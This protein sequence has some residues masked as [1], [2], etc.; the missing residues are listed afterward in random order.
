M[1]GLAASLLVTALLAARLQAQ[2]STLQ[3]SGPF[4]TS[5][6]GLPLSSDNESLTIGPGELG[7]VCR[8]A[9]HVH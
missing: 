1:K 9:R 8:T 5:N 6:F 7:R 2:D 3:N 4:F